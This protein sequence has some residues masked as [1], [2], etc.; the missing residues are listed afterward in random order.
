MPTLTITKTYDD[1][2]VLTEAML[3]DI[4]DSIETFVNTT[5]LNADNIQAGGVG[6]TQLANSAVSTDK[7]ADNAVTA[8]KLSSSASVDA[9]RAVGTD[10]IKDSAITSEKLS[11]DSNSILSSSLTS[12]STSSTTFVDLTNLSVSITTRGRPVLIMAVSDAASAVTGS[13]FAF[14]STV[15]S[16]ERAMIA[17]LRD[18]T[19]IGYNF[20]LTAADISPTT[21]STLVGLPPS[22]MI[23][24]DTPAAGTYTYKLQ[25]KV[26]DGA[27]GQLTVANMKLVAFE[28]GVS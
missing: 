26:S 11:T 18:V 24:Y 10:H 13:G 15:D 3:D 12:Q 4:K 17:C 19:A 23:F 6:T 22:S 16:A 21:S 7:L 14:N 2:Q 9:S 8:A 27:S 20:I 5:K 1:E 28:L 25:G